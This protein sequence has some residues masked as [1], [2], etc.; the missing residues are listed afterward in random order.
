[1]SVSRNSLLERVTVNFT[2]RTSR[3]CRLGMRLTGN[4]ATDVIN[5]Y[6]QVGAYIEWLL[7]RPGGQVFVREPG[8][9]RPHPVR[10]IIGAPPDNGNPVTFEEALEGAAEDWE[11][12]PDAAG[13]SP[14]T[15]PGDS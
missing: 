12:A 14:G 8:D 15:R 1:M 3:A 13:S 7:S 6:V 9:A 10:L 4:N 11:L 2:R 5:R